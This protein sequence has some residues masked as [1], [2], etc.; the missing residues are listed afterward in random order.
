MP[1]TPIADAGH[2]VPGV[3]KDHG[4]DVED[5]PTLALGGSKDNPTDNK[6]LWA[7]FGQ[8]YWRKRESRW[9]EEDKD[10]YDMK[11]ARRRVA[12]AKRDKEWTGQELYAYAKDK[13]AKHAAKETK[14]SV[15]R[16][17]KNGQ[18]ADIRSYF[19]K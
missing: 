4:D 18:M 13:E 10:G 3:G 16:M 15:E 7:R 14:E 9:I 12:S 2:A 17:K 5:K 6:K 8:D 1:D 11:R 19:K